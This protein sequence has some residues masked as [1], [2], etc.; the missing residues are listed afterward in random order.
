MTAGNQSQKWY[1]ENIKTRYRVF[2]NVG[3]FSIGR[4]NGNDLRISTKADLN[5]K[6]YCSKVHC[7]LNLHEGR[8]RLKN[9]VSSILF[10]L[11]YFTAPNLT[12]LQSVC[13]F[14][15]TPPLV[16]YHASRYFDSAYVVRLTAIH[17]NVY[18][19]EIIKM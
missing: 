3:S 13:L 17:L 10:R 1:I 7:I 15:W 4:R 16:A 2:L 19:Y 18:M 8:V 5:G 9:M 12:I 6:E 11:F 14:T